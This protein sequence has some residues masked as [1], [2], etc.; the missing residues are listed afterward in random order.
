MALCDFD[1]PTTVFLTY[2]NLHTVDA[3]Y[4]LVDAESVSEVK[5]CIMGI[6]V[7]SDDDPAHVWWDADAGRVIV[8]AGRVTGLLAGETTGAVIVYDDTHPDGQVIAHTIPF[9]V[10]E[11][12]D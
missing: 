1:A 11:V 12:C 3:D 4:R 7:S 9:N 5:F 10:V 8:R 6:T 2:G